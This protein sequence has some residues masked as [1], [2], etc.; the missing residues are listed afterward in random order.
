MDSNLRSPLSAGIDD[1]VLGTAA[2]LGHLR[3]HL[4]CICSAVQVIPRVA[5]GPPPYHATLR[6]GLFPCAG[7]DLLL[8]GKARPTQALRSDPAI[9]TQ[10]AI[11]SVI[12]DWRN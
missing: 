9:L 12:R 7:Q 1:V 6:N 2:R 5:A 3:S 10:D 8:F 11:L 4:H